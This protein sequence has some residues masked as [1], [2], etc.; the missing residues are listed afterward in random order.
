MICLFHILPYCLHLF[1]ALLGGFYAAH[2][3]ANYCEVEGK[4]FVVLKY[5]EICKV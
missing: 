4:W 1:N 2:G 3:V 5:L